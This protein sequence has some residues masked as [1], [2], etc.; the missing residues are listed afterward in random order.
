MSLDIRP[1]RRPRPLTKKEN[2]PLESVKG[3]VRPTNVNKPTRQRKK[4]DSSQLKWVVIVVVAIILLL[5]G[6]V[7]IR[8]LEQSKVYY[9]LD[10]T[11]QVDSLTKDAKEA[12][13]FDQQKWKQDFSSWQKDFNRWQEISAIVNQLVAEIDD[14]NKIIMNNEE[15]EQK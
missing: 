4:V 10:K 2:L 5:A 12:A 6:I 3:K 9:D 15:Q 14:L 13:A 8:K 7:M 11:S 1:P